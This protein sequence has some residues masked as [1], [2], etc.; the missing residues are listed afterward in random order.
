MK[1]SGRID[2]LPWMTAPET[3]AVVDVLTATGEPARFVGGCVRDAVLG[4]SAKDVDLATPLPPAEVVRRLEAAGLKAI[5]TGIAHGTVTALSG[6]R[7]YEIT[8]LRRDVETFGR[9]ATVAFTDDWTEDAA[10]RD[11]TMNAMFCDRD[12]TLYD[13]FQGRDDLAAGRV[14]F[15][16]DA[17]QRIDEDALRLL[18]FFRFYAHYG[19][20]PPDREAIAACAEKAAGLD[21][22]SGERLRDEMLR[23][24][25]A[26]TAPSVLRLMAEHDVLRHCLPLPHMPDEHSFGRL[27][28][29]IALEQ[30]TRDVDPLRR[31][32]ALVM[33]STAD[34]A[35]ILAGR[36]RLSV[37]RGRRLALMAAPSAVL[38]R[39]ATSA[40]LHQAIYRHGREALFDWALL[41]WADTPPQ[42]GE[43]TWRQ[44]VTEIRS[45]TIPVFPLTG[46]DVLERGLKPGRGVGRLLDAVETWW[47]ERDYEPTR[48]QCLRQLERLIAAAPPE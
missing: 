26:D 22:L 36:L 5:P 16:G 41:G 17:R 14:R 13:P 10:R 3:T 35:L 21:I 2:P 20:P 12:G 7:H 30:R 43:T 15:V 38:S 27:A 42:E 18:R 29:L 28:H 8:T 33:G 44:I 34:E 32:R 37:A 25:E 1:P 9:H 31:L 45:W 46:R 19:H 39:G 24:L 6:D 40:D 11:F 23:L 47:A 48:D 4:R